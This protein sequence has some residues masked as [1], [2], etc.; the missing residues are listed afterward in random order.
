MK[1][2]TVKEKLKV[3]LKK[4]FGIEI[5]GLP[6]RTYAGHVGLSAGDASWTAFVKYSA[7][8]AGSYYT[9]TECITAAKLEKEIC[10]IRL[11]ITPR[12]ES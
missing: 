5:D 12:D 2:L 10:G 8:V 4:D 3:R 7:L 9:M 11:I 6:K 1:R